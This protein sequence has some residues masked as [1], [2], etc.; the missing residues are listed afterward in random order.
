MA[1]IAVWLLLR[2]RPA[3]SVTTGAVWLNPTTGEWEMID[4]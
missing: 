3:A 1:A 2:R 4:G